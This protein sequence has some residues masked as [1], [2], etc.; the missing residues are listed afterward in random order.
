MEELL[1]NVQARLKMDDAEFNSYLSDVTHTTRIL[2]EEKI[3]FQPD[4]RLVFYAH[5]VSLA[6]RLKENISLDCGDDCPEDE[7][8]KEAVK[9]S[10]KIIFPLAEK[11]KRE[12]N[13]M[14]IILAGIQLQLAMDMQKESKK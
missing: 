3:E 9:V 7:L 2:E 5:M 8:D 4:F 13:R 11:Y 6:K 10:E 14:E 1:K 12:L